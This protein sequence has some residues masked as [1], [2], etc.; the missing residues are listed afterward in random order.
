MWMNGQGT[1]HFLW[2]WLQV[3]GMGWQGQKKLLVSS[4]SLQMG[5]DWLTQTMEQGSAGEN[6]VPLGGEEWF[7]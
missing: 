7:G 3:A 2:R 4:C 1:S 5:W 6:S